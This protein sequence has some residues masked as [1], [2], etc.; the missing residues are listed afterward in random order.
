MYLLVLVYN[1]SMKYTKEILQ[2]AVDNSSSLAGVVRYLG[3]KWSGGTQCHIKRRIQK[4]GI[5]FSH[6]TGQAHN[7]GKVSLQKQHWS[8]ILVKDRL[9]R[10]EHAIRLRRAL[11]E[12]GRDYKCAKCGLTEWLGE[13]IILEVNHINRDSQDNTPENVEFICGNCHSQLL[14]TNGRKYPL[15]IL[16]RTPSIKI[17]DTN[18]KRVA[19]CG[20]GKQISSRATQCK[21]CSSITKQIGKTKRPSKEQLEEDFRL[22]KSFVQVGKKYGVS[23]N[24]VRKWCKLYNVSR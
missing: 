5:D 18:S 15:S 3:M 9:D 7:K 24:A 13:V 14:G 22:L 4:F 2:T 23:D 19:V 6:F 10:R 11:I 17:L 16:K 12:S 8:K 20:C 1:T 21:S